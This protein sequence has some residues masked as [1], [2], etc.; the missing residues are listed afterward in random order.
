MKG[1]DAETHKSIVYVSVLAASEDDLMSWAVPNLGAPGGLHLCQGD[2]RDEDLS[3]A[4][5]FLQAVDSW[6]IRD[7]GDLKDEW[8]KHL[9]L[10]RSPCG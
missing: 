1:V 10:W 4:E 9:Q 8:N 7:R 2:A 5:N 6:R 3:G